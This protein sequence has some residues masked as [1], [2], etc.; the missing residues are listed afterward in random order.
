MVL[1]V[2]VLFLF[3]FNALG[4]EQSFFVFFLF[5]LL[6]LELQRLLNKFFVVLNVPK[7]LLLLLVDLLFSILHIVLCPAPPIL[8]LLDFVTKLLVYVFHF[9]FLIKV[10]L[11]FI[12]Y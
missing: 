12:V 4:F 6:L 5:F 10:G 8:M 2:K 3:V 9:E 1:V 7:V 11:D